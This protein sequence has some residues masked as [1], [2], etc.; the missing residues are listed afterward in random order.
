MK[1][2][3]RKKTKSKSRRLQEPLLNDLNEAYC[4]LCGSG[5]FTQEDFSVGTGTKPYLED[6]IVLQFESS[7]SLP[8]RGWG[9]H[10][11]YPP[12]KRLR[13]K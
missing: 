13:G 7:E 6:N 10:T 4:F 5:W 9:F 11:P 3:A 12:Y 8:L 2:T 1:E